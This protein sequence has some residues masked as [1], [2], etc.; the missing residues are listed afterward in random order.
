MQSD[1]EYGRAWA[2]MMGK[3]LRDMGPAFSGLS[4]RYRWVRLDFPQAIADELRFCVC[5]SPGIKDFDNELDAYAALGRAV[6][7]VHAA[8]PPLEQ[9]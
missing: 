2:A 9:S 7:A 1:E 6:R 3:E 5:C 4:K 8:V